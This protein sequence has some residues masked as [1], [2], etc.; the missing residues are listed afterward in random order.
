MPAAELLAIYHNCLSYTFIVFVDVAVTSVRSM[1]GSQIEALRLTHIMIVSQLDIGIV[2]YL[3]QNK[4]FEEEHLDI[5]D[6][7]STDGEKRSTILKI[8]KTRGDKAYYTFLNILPEI[9]Q[10]HLKIKI[11]KNFAAQI[12]G[13]NFT[14]GMHGRR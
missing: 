1:E 12:T 8:L 5:I 13:D 7:T 9:G 4:I 3:Y 11:E 6:S 2:D 14:S 10:A